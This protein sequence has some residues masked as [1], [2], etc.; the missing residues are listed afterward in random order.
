MIVGAIVAFS[1]LCIVLV[2][3]LHVKP[4]T[5]LLLVGLGLLGLGIIRR[6]TAND[7]RD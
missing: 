5:V 7:R 6:L 3:E 4:Y 1:G 2:E